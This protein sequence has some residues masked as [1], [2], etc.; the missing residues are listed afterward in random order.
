MEGSAVCEEMKHGEPFGGVSN[1]PGKL[2]LPAM[3]H[4]L[5]LVTPLR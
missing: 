2:L 1:R 5:W 4:P 3:P